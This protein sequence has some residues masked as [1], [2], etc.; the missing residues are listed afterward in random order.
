MTKAAGVYLPLLSL[1]MLFSAIIQNINA[2]FLPIRGGKFFNGAAVKGGTDGFLRI[3][4]NAG[5]LFLF[6]VFHGITP[7][8]GFHGMGKKYVTAGR[9]FDT[10]V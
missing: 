4:P 7:K 9:G 5:I 2:H 10:G 8:L 1:D 3:D 6:A